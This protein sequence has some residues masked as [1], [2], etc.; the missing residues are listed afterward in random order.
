MSRKAYGQIKTKTFAG[1][2]TA[3]RE[4]QR[5]LDEHRGQVFAM[6]DAIAERGRRIPWS[7]SNVCAAQQRRKIIDR[8]RISNPAFVQR[9]ATD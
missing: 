4:C 6:T 1:K 9:I 7:R 2:C 8:N 3:F 5:P